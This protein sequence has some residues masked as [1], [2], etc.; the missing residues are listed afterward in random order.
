ME[1]LGW[2]LIQYDWWRGENLDTNVYAKKKDHVK[3]QREGCHMEAKKRPQI[4]WIYIL[5]CI[6]LAF[7][8]GEGNGTPLQ[9]A[10]LENPMGGGAW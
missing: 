9:Y 1:Q 10:C 7:I 3:I 6:L 8:T 5:D 4:Q 2:V